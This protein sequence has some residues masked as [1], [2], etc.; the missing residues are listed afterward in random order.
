MKNPWLT[1]D[2]IKQIFFQTNNENPKGFYAGD[3]DI[4]E[5][6]D[7]VILVASHRIAQTERAMCVRFVNTLN[8]NVGRALEEYRGNL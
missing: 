3:L 4:M 7:K 1:E 8:T 2:D 5:F 6:A